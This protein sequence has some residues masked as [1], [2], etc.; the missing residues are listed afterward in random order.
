L[1]RL[2]WQPAF[3]VERGVSHGLE[4]ERAK[5]TVFKVDEDSPQPAARFKKL[6]LKRSDVLLWG[7]VQFDR[8]DEMKEYLHKVY[9]PSLNDPSLI[10]KTFHNSPKPMF[11]DSIHF[12]SK[13]GVYDKEIDLL[14]TAIRRG[15]K[16]KDF[17]RLLQDMN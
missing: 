16:S 9:I 14:N 13:K 3:S 11:Y 2:I 4:F 17:L 15:K 8:A 7:L 10:G 5:K 6:I 12:A 1:G